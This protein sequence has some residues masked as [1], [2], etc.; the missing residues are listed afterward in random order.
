MRNL[1]ISVI[2]RSLNNNTKID[3]NNIRISYSLLRAPYKMEVVEYLIPNGNTEPAREKIYK[4][5]L[6]KLGI[7][8]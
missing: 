8:F 6:L 2:K 7:E 3:G 5:V 1:N 4:N